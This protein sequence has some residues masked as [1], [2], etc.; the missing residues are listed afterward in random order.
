VCAG[1]DVRKS[2]K[3]IPIFGLTKDLIITEKREVL[4]RIMGAYIRERR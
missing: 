4:E 2:H 3:Q 1:Q